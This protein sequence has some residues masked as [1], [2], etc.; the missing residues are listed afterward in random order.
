VLNQQK[1][2]RLALNYPQRF[3]QIYISMIRTPSLKMFMSCMLMEA[4]ES[5][6]DA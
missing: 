4:N 3:G 5:G 6:N 1:K 2:D